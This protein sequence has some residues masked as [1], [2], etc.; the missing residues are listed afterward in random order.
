MQMQP[1]GVALNCLQAEV[2]KETR[3]AGRSGEQERV[4]DGRSGARCAAGGR[5][6]GGDRVR[7]LAGARLA[8][9]SWVALGCV[10]LRSVG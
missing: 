4:I 1:R 10:A 5:G 6:G 7:P 8:E 3:A 9:L 2:E